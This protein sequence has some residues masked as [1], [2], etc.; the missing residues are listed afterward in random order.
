MKKS[1]NDMRKSSYRKEELE[2]RNKKLHD[3][4]AE[5]NLECDAGMIGNKVM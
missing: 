4:N 5:L 1:I 3:K 2:I